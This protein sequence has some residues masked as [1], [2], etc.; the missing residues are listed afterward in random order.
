MKRLAREVPARAALLLVVLALTAACGDGESQSG[1]VAGE[2]WRGLAIAPEERCAPYDRRDYRY[3][4]RVLEAVLVRELGGVYAPYTGRCFRDRGQ[5]D[6]EHIV[7]LSEAHDSGMC[8]RSQGEKV[9]FAGDPLNLTLATP[10]VNREEKRHH[11]A[12]GWLPGKNRCWF[13]AR[14][15]TVRRKYGLTI[16]RAEAQALAD[17]LSACESTEMVRHCEPLRD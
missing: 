10:E 17:V 12:S 7:A 4:S 16:D 2:R 5:T 11:D 6:V 13:A 3:N 1:K 9:L 8:G 15:V 14:V